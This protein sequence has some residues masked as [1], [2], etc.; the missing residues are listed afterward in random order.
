MKSSPPF[1]L[2]SVEHQGEEEN[3]DSETL[4]SPKKEK[5]KGVKS[6]PPGK[7]EDKCFP[8]VAFSVDKDLL[9]E[10]EELEEK[11]FSASLQNKVRCK[12]CLKG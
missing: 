5:N 2:V 11:M 6:S 10:V 7:I 8:Q 12:R 1:F 9:M 3:K 4:K